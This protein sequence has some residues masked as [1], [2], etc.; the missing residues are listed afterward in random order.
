LLDGGGSAMSARA[1]ARALS[2]FEGADCSPEVDDSD[3]LASLE[4]WLARQNARE[5]VRETDDASSRGHSRLLRA[6]HAAFHALPRH[7]K[8]MLSR[9]VADAREIISQLRGASI[10]RELEALAMQAAPSGDASR[11]R[12]LLHS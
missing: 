11:L 7:A 10:E 9:D 8:A 5:A 4:R 2:L 12:E 3:A 1:V 6:L